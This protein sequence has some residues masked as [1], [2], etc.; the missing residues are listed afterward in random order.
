M[1]SSEAQAYLCVRCGGGGG[2]RPGT[3]V[4]E[5]PMSGS[6]LAS[7]ERKQTLRHRED[8]L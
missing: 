5:A 2:G 1:V 3:R 7:R 6:Q 4:R 8:K